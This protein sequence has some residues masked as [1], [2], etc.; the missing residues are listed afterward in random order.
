[1]VQ[2]PGGTPGESEFSWGPGMVPNQARSVRGKIVGP[3]EP[4]IQDMVNRVWAERRTDS[5]DA[6]STAEHMLIGGLNDGSDLGNPDRFG[7]QPALVQEGPVLPLTP[8]VIDPRARGGIVGNLPRTGV[9][10]EP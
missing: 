1:M 6:A 8:Y 10:R 5:T 2:T 7:A 4:G 3:E 9:N